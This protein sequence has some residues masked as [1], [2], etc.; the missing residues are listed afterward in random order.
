MI[1]CEI[2]LT[3]GLLI[4]GAYASWT[5]M[6][7]GLVENRALF[8][9]LLAGIFLDLIYYGF[10]A[11]PFAGLFIK[12]LVAA[13]T[14][15][16]LLFWAHFWAAGD[17]K[18]LI[19]LT[20]LIPGRVFDDDGSLP[21]ITVTVIAFLIAYVFILAD[22]IKA[23]LKKEKALRAGH[24]HIREIPHAIK[25]YLVIFAFHQLVSF[26]WLNL[27]PDFYL[28]NGMLFVVLNLILILTLANRKVFEK[29]S[30]IIVTGV[31]YV[32]LIL[33]VPSWRQADWG[34]LLRSYLVI[35][36]CLGLRYFVGGYNYQELPVSDVKAG[37]ILSY[38]TV[39]QMGT[40]RIKNLPRQTT[41]D[42]QSRLTETE[43][44]A[45]RRWGESSKGRKTVYI[46]RKVPFALFLVLG[47]FLYLIFRL[48]P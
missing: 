34:A 20:V 8:P 41:E 28:R 23:F 29:K 10:F 38:V 1:A 36:L 18:L 35:I 12:N 31:L 9:A 43:A 2:M 16:I 6:R 21:V 3:L 48:V 42:M 14:L 5:D 22:S 32:L 4:L 24:F 19:V 25:N 45:V 37:M 17:S 11:R 27:F 44:E 7:S 46:V 39:L 33:T 47:V 30:V 13:A 15:A 40:S 26:L